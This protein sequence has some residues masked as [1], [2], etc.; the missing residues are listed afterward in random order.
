MWVEE[1]SS[2]GTYFNHSGN[3]S[4]G[5]I[6]LEKTIPHSIGTRV[7]LEF[8]LPGDEQ[9]IRVRAEI[10]GAQ[11][12]DEKFGMSLQFVDAP[13][14]VKERIRGFVERAARRA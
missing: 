13:A 1:T 10:V 5:G 12:D 2:D 14:D 8:T 11:A 9:P 7:Q 6:Y 3:L 4:T